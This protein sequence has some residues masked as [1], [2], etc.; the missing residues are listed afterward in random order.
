M[1]VVLTG[2][3]GAGKTTVGS[4]LARFLGWPFVDLDEVIERR[5]GKT[6]R[7]IFESHGEAY[8]RQLEREVFEQ[9]LR[10]DPVVIAAGGG[11]L[12]Q[13]AN[14][15]LAFRSALVVWINTGFS[16]IAQRVAAGKKE[17]RPLF[18]DEVTAWKLYQER[19]PT[20]RRAHLTVDVTAD[21]SSS[22]VA[23]RIVGLL[24][25]RSCSI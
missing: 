6:I 3:M 24:R 9:A 18:R 16:L 17:D 1:K 8:F 22:S 11:T 10:K 13:E 25:S 14:F 23:L 19:L 15:Q 2:F 4:E 12:T 21:E 20:Y 7:E 5:T